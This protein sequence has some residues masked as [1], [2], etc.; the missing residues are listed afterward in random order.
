VS[1]RYDAIGVFQKHL[2]HVRH[3]GLWNVIHANGEL[4][5]PAWSPRPPAFT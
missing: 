1:G 4:Q 2:A 5:K 3:N